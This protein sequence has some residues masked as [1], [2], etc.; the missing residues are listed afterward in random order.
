MC[1]GGATVNAIH[2]C[3]NLWI[4]GKTVTGLHGLVFVLLFA[5]LGY[6]SQLP[7]GESFKDRKLERKVSSKRFFAALLSL[8]SLGFLLASF[9]GEDP[10]RL[11]FALIGLGLADL[12]LFL[13]LRA[14]WTDLPVS[15]M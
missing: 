5:K 3:Y 11:V 10:S 2:S 7:R 1:F 6:Y 15:E 9:N 8:A 12:S 4:V 14:P 13:L